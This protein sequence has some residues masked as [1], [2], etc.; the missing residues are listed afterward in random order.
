MDTVTIP[1]MQA[2]VVADV[3]VLVIGGGPAGVAAAICS[4]REGATTLLAERCGYLGGLATGALVIMLDDMFD[5]TE[6]TVAGIVD[7]LQDRLER[8][9]ALVRPSRHELWRD[10]PDLRRKWARWGCLDDRA[11]AE[12]FP[13]AYRSIT[14]VEV[15]KHVLFQ[16]VSEARVAMRLHSW[17]VQALMEE[18]AVKGA[19]FA[20]K[21]GYQAVRS[22]VTIDATG[23]GDVFAS[24]GA[25]H[26]HGSHII[27]LPHFFGNVNTEQALDFVEQN[28]AEAKRLDAEVRRIYGGS[29]PYWW[30]LT[31]NPGVVWC[32][33][34][35]MSGYSALSVEDLTYLE[36]EGRRR[37]WQVLDFVRK[38]YPG[39]QNAYVARTS[40][41][42]GVRQSRLLVGEYTLTAE[43]IRT[44]RRFDDAV[45]R[46]KGYYYPYRCFVP[47]AVDN[48][49]VAGRHC[50]MEPQAQRQAREWPPCMVTGQAVG[51]AA[52]LALRSQVKV[53]DVDVVTLRNRLRAQ[54]VKLS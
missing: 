53:R 31:T 18:D 29:W 16:M 9:G 4:A 12:P 13:V 30:Q 17:F 20:T 39:F 34:P 38:N 24:A 52:A 19:V 28:P 1:Q 7:E 14:D 8:A 25:E 47:K 54:G 49:L 48:L 41:Q 36:V 46:G 44:R 21:A 42:I 10:T 45:G 33:C 22:R 51:T 40:D 15:A 5:G 37:I 26:V 2:P 6:I 35:H 3:D 11:H 27:T 32:N 23:D 50:A 43:D